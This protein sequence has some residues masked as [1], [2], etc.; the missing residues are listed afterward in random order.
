MKLKL[1]QI[2]AFTSEVFKGNPAAVC[3]LDEWL[4]DSLMQS[5]ATENN[6]SETAFFVQQ[7]NGYRIRWFTPIAEVDLCG[8]ATLASG[9]VVLNI[10]K[11][12][13]TKVVFDSN[14]GPLTVKKLDDKLVLDFPLQIPQPCDPPDD[15][16]AGLGIAPQAV[17]AADD[18]VVVFKNESEIRQL[19]PD[20]RL[21]QKLDRRGV[22]TTA[23]GD[24][25]DFVSRCFFPNYGIDE[26]PVTGSAHCQLTPY[27]AERLAKKKFE[28][29]QI[30]KRGGYLSC[31][32]SQD[33]VFIAG[34]AVL[35]LIGLIHL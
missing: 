3:P 10:L 12:E 8:H 33:R 11:P 16:I 23:P 15:L 20:M 2:D 31:E 14:S 21:L 19:S 26:D 18:Y 5:I 7:G 6:L 4:D 25:V 22:L 17:L 29:H 32:I 30:S 9:F 24:N 35:Y 27:W 1:Y 28:A 34:D 13:Q